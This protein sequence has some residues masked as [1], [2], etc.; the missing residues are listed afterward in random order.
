[1]IENNPFAS[2]KEL[3][4]VPDASHTDLY[5]NLEKIPF[6]KLEDFFRENLHP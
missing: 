5:D 6:Q 4:I 2:N 1:M 3:Y